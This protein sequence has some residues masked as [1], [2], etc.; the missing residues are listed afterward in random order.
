M[1]TAEE[2]RRDWGFTDENMGLF[3]ALKGPL[4]YILSENKASEGN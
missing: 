2:V 4:A 3:W 1:S